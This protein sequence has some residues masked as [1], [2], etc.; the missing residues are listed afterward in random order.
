MPALLHVEFSFSKLEN[1]GLDWPSFRGARQVQQNGLSSH[2]RLRFHVPTPQIARL[3]KTYASVAFLDRNVG[4]VLED[5]WATS[6]L[7]S[8]QCGKCW[9]NP[10]KQESSEAREV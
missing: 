3:P 9:L 4:R 6:I 7:E 10:R 8:M 5:S 2:G 1:S